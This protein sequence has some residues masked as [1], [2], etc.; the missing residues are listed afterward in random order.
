[1]SAAGLYVTFYYIGGSLGAIVTGW[2]WIAG[3]WPACVFLLM[4]VA[5]LAMVLAFVSSRRAAVS[6]Q[7]SAQDFERKI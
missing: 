7:P 5:A 6:H 3:G 1:S 4:G 2:T